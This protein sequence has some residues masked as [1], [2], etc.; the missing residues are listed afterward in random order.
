MVLE[1]GCGCGTESL[2]MA[3]NGAEVDGID[4]NAERLQVAERRRQVLERELNRPLKAR[5]AVQ[6]VLAMDTPAQYDIIWMEQAFHH[7][8]PRQ[9]VVEKLA[10]LLRPNGVVIISE[11]NAMNPLLQ[12]QLF[13]KRGFRTTR[14]FTDHDG[15]THCYG[16]ERVLSAGRLA[17]LMAAVGIDREN[18]VHYR[19]F[20]NQQL[21]KGLAWL[22]DLVPGAFT[23]L[24]SHYNFI[25]KK[26]S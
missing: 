25:G 12:L 7:L 2:W 20:P 15:L 23:P 11:V 10:S 18:V 17:K 13:M 5:F 4:I 8:E 14:E 22:E 24:F 26:T 1:V 19:I 6:S 16:N 9:Q 3:L 21:F